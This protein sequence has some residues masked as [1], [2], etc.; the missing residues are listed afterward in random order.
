MSS[1]AIEALSAGLAEA[2]ERASRAVVAV[3]ARHR[4]PSSG[5]IWQPGVVVTAAHTVKRDEEITVTVPDGRTLPATLAGRDTSTDLAVLRVDDQ[6]AAAERGD[7]G[8]LRVGSLALA[9]S[10]A[11]DGSPNASLGIVGALGGPWRT[12]RGGAVDRFIRLD[13]RLYAGFSGGPLA[14]ARGTVVGVNTAGL[15]RSAGLTIPAE[16]VDRVAGELLA[17]GRVARGFLGVGMQPV[18]LPDSV[19]RGLQIENSTGVMVLGVEPDGPAERGGL[20]IGDVVVALDGERVEDTDDVQA[21]LGGE[22]VGTPL[23]VTVVRAGSLADVT[24]TVGE[25]P[26]RG[27]R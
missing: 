23:R 25:W 26:R 3:H 9:V 21:A 6:L 5:T 14:D 22:R 13:V 10:R 16:T 18:R 7:P 20:L 27:A 1:Q 11:G 19:A 15:S 2:V 8:A 12:W 24:V 4:V 17:R